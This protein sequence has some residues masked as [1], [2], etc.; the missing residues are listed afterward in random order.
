M[1]RSRSCPLIS[2]WGRLLEVW[3][4]A[5]AA[6]LN[7]MIF[8]CG[9]DGAGQ[10][11][12]PWRIGSPNQAPTVTEGPWVE[13]FGSQM[14]GLQGVEGTMVC[15][16]DVGFAICFWVH[17]QPLWSQ[18]GRG[19]WGG[20]VWLH[21]SGIWMSHCARLWATFWGHPYI[22]SPQP[23]WHQGPTLFKTL[24]PWMWVGEWFR[25]DS[26]TLDLL[27]LSFYYYC[28]SS[29]SHSQAL[30]SGDLGTLALYN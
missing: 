15:S 3:P 6:D 27:C 29:T 16:W 5:A 24:F 11:G 28:I 19:G 21:L 1:R 20:W 2:L 13:S 4:I 10:E 8:P 7:A 12:Q 25:D 30:D 22:S 14:K 9:G 17:C 23:F 18:L 26:D